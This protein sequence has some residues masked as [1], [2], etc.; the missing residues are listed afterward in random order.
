MS[1]QATEDMSAEE[2]SALIREATRRWESC[3]YTSGALFEQVRRLREI[4]VGFIMAN[5][6]IAAVAGAEG[7]F[8]F[9]PPEYEPV[10]VFLAVIA[11]LLPTLYGA[12]KFDD[13]LEQARALS[14]EYKTLEYEYRYL[15]TVAT[16]GDTKIL[17]ARYDAASARFEAAAQQAFTPPEWAFEKTQAKIKAGTY[18]FDGAPGINLKGKPDK[19]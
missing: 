11:G 18:D 15:I 14:G 13:G 17:R 4:K 3:L 7:L 5:V 6:A 9:L 2:H 12:L 19:V 10:P 16:H 1:T 8:R